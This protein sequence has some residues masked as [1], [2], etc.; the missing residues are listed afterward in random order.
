MLRIE[1]L[2]N[3]LD[4]MF[5]EWTTYQFHTPITEETFLK[6]ID[7]TNYYITHE[8]VSHTGGSYKNY[9]FEIQENNELYHMYIIV[10]YNKLDRI[11]SILT[12][13]II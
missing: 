9:T 7:H 3:K 10:E 6:M 13:N 11:T 2:E 8:E 4:N 12:Y 1:L 5:K